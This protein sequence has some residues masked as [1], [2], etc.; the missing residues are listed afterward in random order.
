MGIIDKAE[1]DENLSF[2][3]I[4]QP[5]Y[6]DQNI[7][8]SDPEQQTDEEFVEG[9][10]MIH[11]KENS[12]GKTITIIIKYKKLIVEPEVPENE[13]PGTENPVTP[14]DEAVEEETQEPQYEEKQ[15][16][17]TITVLSVPIDSDETPEAG[18]TDSDISLTTE[19]T[20]GEGSG[21][22]NSTGDSTDGTETQPDKKTQNDIII[23]RL[24]GYNIEYLGEKGDY[25]GAQEGYND[26]Y[27]YTIVDYFV[28]DR[29]HWEYN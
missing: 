19:G 2:F 28:H 12:V 3:T 14:A 24:K 8:N 27:S 29:V 6:K 26:V 13:Q 23:K 20:E 10:G 17:I 18:E 4:N 15:L 11:A 7:D 21:S 5:K 25:L 16:E 9:V 1:S 22:D